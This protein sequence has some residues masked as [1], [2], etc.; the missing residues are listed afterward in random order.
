MG[1]FD[2]F[3]KKTTAERNIIKLRKLRLNTII[4]ESKSLMHSMILA[5]PHD[6][7]FLDENPDGEGLFGLVKS[8]P[9][10]IYGIDNIPAYMDRLR[11]KFTSK[12][13]SGS[14]TF[15]TVDY[16]RTTDSDIT[17]I[18]S[19][20]PT[21]ETV[22]SSVSSPNIKGHIDVYNLY[23]VG[24]QKLAK[25]YI[26]SYSLKTS[27]KIPE[28]FIHRDETPAEKDTIVLIELMK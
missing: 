25:I 14:F 2:I 18:G 27:H 6:N 3:K 20:K 12:S 7:S 4:H 1:L 11:Y 24:G 9:V 28:G 23:S 21:E 19:Q 13:G 15:N 16:Q 5:S 10:P 26:N 8:N 17:E 22:A